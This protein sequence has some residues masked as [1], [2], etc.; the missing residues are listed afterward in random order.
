MTNR[1]TIRN[2]FLDVAQVLEAA[3][4]AGGGTYQT[5]T[6]GQAV[7]FRHRAYT[8]MKK[9][10]EADSLNVS[11]FDKLLLKALD[12][13]EPTTVRIE[14]RKAKG[15]FTPANEPSSEPSDPT[16]DAALSVRKS[17]GLD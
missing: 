4:N 6:K 8:F 15:S 12:P 1:Q 14:I 16:L 9:Y 7:S 3:L 17:L 5:E 11:H 13:N 2:Q 10:R